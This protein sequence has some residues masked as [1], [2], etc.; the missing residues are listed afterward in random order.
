MNTPFKY[1][2]VLVGG[3]MS[4][5]KAWDETVANLK[6]RLSKWKLKTL[7]LGGRLT[8]LKSVLGSTS[9]YNMSLFK[10]PKAV[11]NMMEGLRRNF[12]NGIQEGERKISWVKW[13][14][15][16][17]HG[18]RSQVL[19][20]AH[21]SLWSSIISSVNSLKDQGV[22]IMSHFKI[23]IGNGLRTSF[24]KDF[25]IGDSQLYILFPRLFTLE[26]VK[27]ISVA[28]KLNGPLSASFRRTVRGGVESQQYEILSSLLEVSILSNT[29][30]R[31]VCDLNGDGS[32]RVKDVRNWID[33]S[34]L[35]KAAVPTRWFKSV[36]IK[37][38]IFAW[39]L[40][41]DRLPTRVN[42]FNRKVVV[43]STSC[44]LCDTSAEDASH[45]FFGCV[46]AKQVLKLVF[47]WWNLDVQ[48]FS[49]YDDWLGWFKSIRISFKLKDILEGVFYVTWWRMWNFR[50][51]LLFTNNHPRKDH[52][53][54]D[55]VS[56]SF[57]WCLARGKVRL[58]W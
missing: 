46:L 56:C 34:F 15:S 22:D 41:L 14:I 50:N 24:W 30:D 55:I 20:A 29:E 53:F 51:Q 57:N 40:F 18:S 33:D 19:S 47:R 26:S 44:P 37:I 23:R 5:N 1:L 12:F 4:L 28:E 52:I 21:P 27:D 48:S 9:I 49:S 11:L 2:G 32:F 25:W 43:S 16:G 8:L 10:V 38:N 42:L 6:K 58:N 13:V 36:P 7:S 3:N 45:L 39:K 35:P 31:W 54:D 17:I